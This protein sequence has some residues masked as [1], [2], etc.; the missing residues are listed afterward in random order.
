MST[1]G[2]LHCSAEGRQQLINDTVCYG[3]SSRAAV[4]GAGVSGPL[5]GVL[6]RGI[7]H[8]RLVRLLSL[9]QCRQL[10]V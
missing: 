4:K 3:S 2:C 5:A 7:L 6:A 1:N 10:H 9:T 8:T